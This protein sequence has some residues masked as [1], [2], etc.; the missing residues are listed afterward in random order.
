MLTK[1]PQVN[2]TP[3]VPAIP[4]RPERVVCPPVP[5]DAAP[6]PGGRAGYYTTLCVRPFVEINGQIFE[7]GALVCTRVWVDSG[8]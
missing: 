5:P 8:G 6:I 1:L 7:S 4:G 3:R 2:Y